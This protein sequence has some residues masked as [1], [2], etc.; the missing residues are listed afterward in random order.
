MNDDKL[1]LLQILDCMR[2][3]QEYTRSGREAFMATRMAQDAVI[4]NFEIIGEA[5]KRV[6]D[7]LREK[8]PDVPWRR[9]A[10]LRDVLIHQ[11]NRVDLDEVWNIVERDV[12]DLK[13]KIEAILQGLG[14]GS[15]NT[16]L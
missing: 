16:N 12:P 14:E 6:S 5:T 9:L 11:Y 4:R 8:H 7:T 2:Q 3:I 13:R 10:G 1:Y 15:E